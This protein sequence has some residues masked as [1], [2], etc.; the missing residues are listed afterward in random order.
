[1]TQ[2][3]IPLGQLAERVQHLMIGAVS[4]SM[5]SARYTV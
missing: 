1:M 3:Q 4:N 5:Y 2:L